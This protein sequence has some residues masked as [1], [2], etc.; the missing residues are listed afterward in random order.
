M[1][2][3]WVLVAE[4]HQHTPADCV[5]ADA[6]V[7]SERNHTFW[8]QEPKADSVIPA[9]RFTSPCATGVRGQMRENFSRDRY[10]RR[11]LIETVFSVAKRK[12]SCRGPD[13]TVATQTRQAL[14]LDITYNL[15]RFWPPNEQQACQQRQAISYLL[16]RLRSAG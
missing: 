5:L 11:S 1:F 7:E 9:K 4:T 10:A 3:R 2:M 14:L 16:L 15:Y 13:R 8:R 12:L 6:E